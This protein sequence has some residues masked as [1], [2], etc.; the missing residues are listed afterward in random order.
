MRDCVEWTS[1]VGGR[2]VVHPVT[3][4]WEGSGGRLVGDSAETGGG[5]GSGGLS[6]GLQEGTSPGVWCVSGPIEVSGGCLILGVPVGRVGLDSGLTGGP[7]R[8]LC[9]SNCPGERA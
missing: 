1:P 7:K 5:V 2:G 9:R 4:V 8:A 3:S 6:R